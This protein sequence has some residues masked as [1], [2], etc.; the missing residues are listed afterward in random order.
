M[1]TS[2]TNI[3]VF[4]DEINTMLSRHEDP[5]AINNL[6]EKLLK[7]TTKTYDTICFKYSDIRPIKDIDRRRWDYIGQ[8]IAKEL[9]KRNHA[10]DVLDVGTGSGRD[11]IYA[12]ELGYNV[13]GIDNSDGFIKIL[14]QLE[15]K[16]FIPPHSFFQCDMRSLCFPDAKF[17]VVRHNAT[18]LHL[19][20]I[21]KGYMA[22]LAISEANRVLKPGG[23]IFISVKKG[24]E[25]EFIDTDEGLGGRVFQFYSH[26]MLTALLERNGFTILDTFDDVEE[27]VHSTIEWICVMAKKQE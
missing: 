23:L 3:G 21:T 27:R 5:K 7:A 2:E 6:A 10:V 16:G 24:E 11:I 4:V 12:R 26:D 13:V 20:M 9:H 8:W 15:A 18:L 17:D 22:D 25:I 1:A 19:P 14:S